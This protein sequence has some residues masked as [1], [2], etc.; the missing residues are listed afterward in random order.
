MN[1]TPV[2]TLNIKNEFRGIGVIEV[3]GG[4]FYSYFDPS[5]ADYDDQIV[6]LAEGYE[7]VDMG[8]GMFEV[9]KIE[10]GNE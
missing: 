10:E 2:W 3:Y 1:A 5:R 9:R 6:F 4:T 7:S 8:E